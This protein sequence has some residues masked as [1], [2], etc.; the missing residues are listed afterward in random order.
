[1]FL[2]HNYLIPIFILGVSTACAS[3]TD[4]GSTDT[5]TGSTSGLDLKESISLDLQ[6][7]DSDRSVMVLEWNFDFSTDLMITKTMTLDFAGSSVRSGGSIYVYG[8]ESAWPENMPTSDEPMFIEVCNEGED[9]SVKLKNF[10]N[11]LTAIY[12]A[13]EITAGGNISG[14]ATATLSV[15]HGTGN[16]EEFGELGFTVEVL[17]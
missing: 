9:F 8:S 7:L 15:S 16:A 6:T 12:T 10:D 2:R 5:D 4:T 17:Q 14:E 11:E 1:M 13:Y 3:S